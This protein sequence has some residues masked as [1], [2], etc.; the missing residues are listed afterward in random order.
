[1]NTYLETI[2]MDCMEIVINKR[3]DDLEQEIEKI[4]DII[5]KKLE[6][7]YSIE[8]NKNPGKF[9]MNAFRAA[10]IILAHSRALSPSF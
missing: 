9:N 2:P 1:M 10:V 8:K 6:K 3:T 4:K 5:M 7:D